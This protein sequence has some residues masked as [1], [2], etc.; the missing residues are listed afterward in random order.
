MD[1]ADSHV[2]HRRVLALGISPVCI[3]NVFH[4]MHEGVVAKLVEVQNRGPGAQCP[5]VSDDTPC[6]PM[7]LHMIA[8]SS[9]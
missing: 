4:E 6:S 8:G 2:R 5:V 9:S 1:I 3:V 7:D